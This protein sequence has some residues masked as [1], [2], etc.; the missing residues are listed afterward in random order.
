VQHEGQ[1]FG[2]FKAI[3]YH[4]QRHSHR[5]G[6]QGLLFRVANTRLVRDRLELCLQ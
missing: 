6:K 5:I 3:E 2:W 4:E 1:T